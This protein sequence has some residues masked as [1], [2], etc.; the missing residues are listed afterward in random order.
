[1]MDIG[2][3]EIMRMEI[4]RDKIGYYAWPCLHV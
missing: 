4:D 1:M 3:V 2:G